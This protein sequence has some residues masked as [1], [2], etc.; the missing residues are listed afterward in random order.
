MD[1][2]WDP[3]KAASNRSKHGIDFADVTGVFFDPLALTRADDDPEEERYVT[4]GMDNLVRI[5]VV[6]YGWREKRIRIISARNATRT[7]RKLYEEGQ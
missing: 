2:E 4:I 3:R 6:V 5:I 1:F 7:E